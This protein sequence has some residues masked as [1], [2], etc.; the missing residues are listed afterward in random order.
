MDYDELQPNV[1]L[2]D[3]NVSTY[4]SCVRTSFA[5]ETNPCI[6]FLQITEKQI[7]ARARTEA[8][9][10]RLRSS[11][12]DLLAN[13][14][15]RQSNGDLNDRQRIGYSLRTWTLT[16]S[17]S[18]CN[19]CGSMYMNQLKETMSNARGRTERSCVCKK[20]PRYFVPRLQDWPIVLRNL[21][22]GDQAVLAVYRLYV[23]SRQRVQHGYRRK[24]GPVV[25]NINI[26]VT[27]RI[28]AIEDG[29]RRRKIEH[30][31]DFLMTC[32]ESK[33][34]DFVTG[35]MNGTSPRKLQGKQLFQ[36]R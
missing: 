27:E 25:A 34:R 28:R 26:P 8:R 6:T 22:T 21:E 12:M 36:V 32:P 31:F 2:K 5:R 7:A 9:V 18:S 30:A 13:F 15:I 33:Y 35:E 4:L 16:M 1:I 20:Y 29:D 23:G 3:C 11:A 24:D 10:N 14:Q 17:S 19:D